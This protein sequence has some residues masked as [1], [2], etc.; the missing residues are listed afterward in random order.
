MKNSPIFLIDFSRKFYLTKFNYLDIFDNMEMLNTFHVLDGNPLTLHN[1]I[2]TAFYGNRDIKISSSV[3]CTILK[4]MFC[5][6]LAFFIPNIVGNIFLRTF[7]S[8][9]KSQ[10]SFGHLESVAQLLICDALCDLVPFVQFKKHENHPWRRINF[11]KVTGFA[12]NFTKINT[13]PLESF[14]FF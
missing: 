1:I 11:S 9:S 4:K 5:P 10:G 12:C 6:L 8:E 13:P 2:S 7:I 3:L 14:T